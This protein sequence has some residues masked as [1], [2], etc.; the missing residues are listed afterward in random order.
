MIVL[1]I[2]PSQLSGVVSQLSGVVSQPSG[3]VSQPSEDLGGRER[4]HRRRFRGDEEEKS[5]LLRKVTKV[6]QDLK[7][8]IGG[9]HAVDMDVGGRAHDNRVECMTSVM[10]YIFT[11]SAA[12][13]ACDAQIRMWVQSH[14]KESQQYVLPSF[15]SL[16][17]PC[18]HPPVVRDSCAQ[19]GIGKLEFVPRKCTGF[20]EEELP[21]V[22][23]GTNVLF[24]KA[25]CM[26]A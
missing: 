22:H 9:G 2:P 15:T 14:E 21:F 12:N 7:L 18:S 25:G 8:L 19:T 10:P 17:V 11:S 13:Q 16:P 3:V 5:T 26:S 4:A 20:L 1:Q 23:V 6:G 24:E